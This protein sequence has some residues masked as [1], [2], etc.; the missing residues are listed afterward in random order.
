MLFCW[1]TTLHFG[2]V[3]CFSLH[4]GCWDGITRRRYHSELSAIFSIIFSHHSLMS[5]S[6]ISLPYITSS[7][8]VCGEFFLSRQIIEFWPFTLVG[9]IQKPLH[10]K[11]LFGGGNK[12]SITPLRVNR[13]PV[14]IRFLAKKATFNLINPHLHT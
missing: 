6:S 2:C 7:P 14:F 10:P 5:G 4:Q 13:S 1:Y 8:R 12:I 11:E 3:L 9:C